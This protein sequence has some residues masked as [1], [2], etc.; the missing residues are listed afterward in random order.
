MSSQGAALIYY[1]EQEYRK[2]V[3]MLELVVSYVL[4]PVESLT[5][6]AQAK[7]LTNRHENILQPEGVTLSFFFI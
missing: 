2:N 6:L 5:L 7:R 4:L 1:V 3:Y